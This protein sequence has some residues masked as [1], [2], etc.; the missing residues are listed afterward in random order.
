[1]C[2]ISD[3]IVQS[4]HGSGLCSV[5]RQSDRPP[6]SSLNIDFMFSIRFGLCIRPAILP[7][8]DLWCLIGVGNVS[9]APS[10]TLDV[11]PEWHSR[12]DYVY[13]F[14]SLSFLRIQCLHPRIRTVWHLTPSFGTSITRC[15]RHIRFCSVKLS[16]AYLLFWINSSVSFSAVAK[17]SLKWSLPSHS[18][19]CPAS[20]LWMPS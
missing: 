4:C 17:P 20:S 5:P 13:H 3:P 2:G 16:R 9:L 11:R 6:P 12:V 10:H 19:L 1:M 14:L 18:G 8:R 15:R 7:S